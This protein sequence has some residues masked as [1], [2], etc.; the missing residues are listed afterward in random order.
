MNYEDKLSQA[1]FERVANDLK[2]GILEATRLI[3]EPGDESV[4][5]LGTTKI[6]GKPDLPV[7]TSW[8]SWNGSELSFIAQINL[9]DFGKASQTLLPKKGLLSY[10]SKVMGH[11]KFGFAA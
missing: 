10:A 4:L 1:I 3:T 6:G 9:V 5:E 2:S 7:G 11:V 8:P